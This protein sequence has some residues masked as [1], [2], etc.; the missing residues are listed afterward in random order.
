MMCTLR[1]SV[2]FGVVVGVNYIK[3][4]RINEIIDAFTRFIFKE[5]RYHT[6]LAIQ[7]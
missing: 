3:R 7:G 5:I 4:G 2:F 6:T 1:V